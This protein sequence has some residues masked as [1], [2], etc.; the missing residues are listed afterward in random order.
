MLSLLQSCTCWPPSSDDRISPLASVLA[1]GRRETAGDRLNC[2]APHRT[3]PHW[4]PP[5]GTWFPPVDSISCPRTSGRLPN[6]QGFTGLAQGRAPVHRSGTVPEPSPPP[7]HPP[8]PAAGLAPATTSSSHEVSPRTGSSYPAITLLN[9]LSTAG[10]V[11][12]GHGVRLWAFP[13]VPSTSSRR[14]HPIYQLSSSD[15]PSDD[16]SPSCRYFD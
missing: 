7:L 15:G 1:A 14:L 8:L 6:Q 10:H 2:T 16:F 3:A 5:P 9:L 11:H 4:N 13:A 12:V